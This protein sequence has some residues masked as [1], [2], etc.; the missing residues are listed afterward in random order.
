MIRC[1]NDGVISVN[2]ERIEVFYVVYCDVVVVS[3]MNDFVFE[4][5]LVF[6]RFFDEDLG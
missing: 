6:E 4:F 5:F 3:I 1:D 2:I